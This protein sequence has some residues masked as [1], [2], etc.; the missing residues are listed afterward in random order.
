[1]VVVAMVC[2]G[3]LEATSSLTQLQLL[4]E[5][6]VREQSQGPVNGRQGDF[7]LL[8]G[9]LLMDVL[10]AEVASGSKPFEQIQHT[11][12]LRRQ[13]TAALMQPLLQSTTVR[14]RR[15]GYGQRSRA[16]VLNSNH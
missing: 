11:P 4:K 2:S 15:R 16:A 14:D 10:R 12:P 13:P 5:A 1:M 9:Q 7:Q 3:E 8:M 6:H